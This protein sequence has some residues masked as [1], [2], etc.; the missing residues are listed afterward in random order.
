MITTPSTTLTH[1]DLL[2]DSQ[3]RGRCSSRQ[4]RS[5][6]CWPSIHNW[7]VKKAPFIP[8]SIHRANGLFQRTLCFSCI[9]KKKY[10]IVVILMGIKGAFLTH[11][12]CI[13]G[14]QFWDLICLDEE[15][16]LHW[17][18]VGKSSWVSVVDGVA[19]IETKHEFWSAPPISL[20]VNYT[21]PKSILWMLKNLQ[22]I[23]NQVHQKL[24]GMVTI[25]LG[26][27]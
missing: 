2:T 17:E 9:C 3:S 23:S 25:L 1:L 21:I 5:Q 10:H 12:L 7:C 26:M 11:C 27:V 22:K 13:E 15:R 19:I 18:Y 16:P 4:I 14:Q 20:M 24:W 6:N 8:I